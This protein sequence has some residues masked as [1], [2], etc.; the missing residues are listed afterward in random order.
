MASLVLA[1]VERTSLSDKLKADVDGG[2]LKIYTGASPGPNSAATGTLLATFTIPTGSSANGV[3]TFGS[4]SPAT[5]VADGVAGY[6]RILK[7][8]GSVVVC[9]GDVAASGATMNLN[10]TS[11]VN[12]QQVSITSVALTVPA[13]S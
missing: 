7:S 13:G 5:A 9:D 11:I 2:V 10:N 6:F 4:F 12:G 3:Y 1:T 8:G